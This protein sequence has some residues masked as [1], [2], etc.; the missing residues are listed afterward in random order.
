MSELTI[1]V[2]GTSQRE[3]PAERV[4][5]RLRLAADG[6]DR[7]ALVS[8]VGTQ[9]AQ[10]TSQVEQLQSAGVVSWWA[11]DQLQAWGERPWS[12]DGVQLPVV[13][14]AAVELRV[15]FVDFAALGV[16]LT[17]AAAA[18]TVTVAGL[19]WELEDDTRDSITAQVQIAAVHDAV[20]RASRYAAALGHERVEAVEVT[21]PADP[22]QPGVMAMSYR[23]GGRTGG[24]PAF[25]LRPEEVSVRASVTARFRVVV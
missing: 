2:T 20:T 9:H 1:V 12:N 11:S 8:E 10:L 4:T 7:D 13:H 16:W 24:A 18:E 21:E 5:V 19:D 6:S 25:E 22:A 14:H 3:V 23:D 15:R 17:E